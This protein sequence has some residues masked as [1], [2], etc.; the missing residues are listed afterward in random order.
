VI[1][2]ALLI[3]VLASAQTLLTAAAVD[4]LH[5]GPRTRYD[6]E[7]LAQGVGNCLCGLLGALP[8]AGVIVRSSANLQAGAQSRWS[9]VLH[10]LWLLIFVVA[11]G[12]LLKMIPT[13]AL[14]A[15]LV[16]TGYKLVDWQQVRELARYGWA[17]A[18]IYAATLVGVVARDL[19]TGVLIGLGLE[20]LKLA[21]QSSRLK[22]RARRS[23][24]DTRWEIR[25]EGRATFLK[26]PKLARALER[27]PAGSAVSLEADTLE[28]LDHACLELI[29]SWSAQVTATGGEVRADWRLLEALARHDAAS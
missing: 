22:I 8:V 25:L 19:L 6:R 12:G 1:S 16:Y 26:L 27:V 24:A 13:S 4:A 17:E 3:A 23:D 5:S 28:V 9:A 11:L 18:G 20:I 21:F 10:G 7:L 14:A 2:A 15:I 29:K